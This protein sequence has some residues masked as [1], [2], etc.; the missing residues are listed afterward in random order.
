MPDVHINYRYT[1]APD[2]PVVDPLGSA[3]LP[4]GLKSGRQLLS[5]LGCQNE[6]RNARYD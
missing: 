2:S 5:V 3:R 4:L 6:I 1:M